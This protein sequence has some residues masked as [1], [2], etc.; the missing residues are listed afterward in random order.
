MRAA[1]VR[2]VGVSRSVSLEPMVAS[3]G[4]AGR[5]KRWLTGGW[6]SPRR[7]VRIAAAASALVLLSAG[8]VGLRSLARATPP[9]P[10]AQADVRSQA[11][12][13]T[14]VLTLITGDQV[15]VNSS[16]VT[17]FIPALGRPAHG[18]ITMVV[19]GHTHVVPNDMLGVVPRVL[20][21]SLFDVEQ[22]GAQHERLA[23]AGKGD[24]VRV[25]S[26]GGASSAVAQQL[27]AGAAS[28]A[29]LSSV[30]ATAV[31]VSRQQGQKIG[32]SVAAL[33]HPGKP[34]GVAAALRGA[35]PNKIWL[36]RVVR[37]DPV[38]PGVGE[39]D[40]GGAFAA[41]G[42]D[43]NLQQIKAPQAWQAKLTGKGFTVAVLDSGVDTAHPDLV[44]VVS[45]SK[46]FSGADT[47]DRVG[48]GTHVAGLIAGTGVL[49]PQQR[50]GVAYQAK[51]L[52]GKVLDDTGAGF[53][54]SIIDGMQWAVEKKAS[55]INMSLG[56]AVLYQNDPISVALDRL[57]AT[58]N[59]LFVVAAG[60][61]GAGTVGS[62]GMAQRALTVG[63]VDAKGDIAPFSSYGV[64]Y[65]TGV[66]P[67]LTAPGVKIVSD[68]STAVTP[69][70]CMG[71]TMAMSGT[72]MA[73]P[74]VAG[75]AV[76]V[77]QAHPT[78]TPAQV[79]AALVASAVTNSSES[80][81]SQGGG[82]VDIPAAVG[83]SVVPV[84]ATADAG[85]VKLGQQ[86][87]P[88]TG[89]LSW[90]NLGAKPV[91]LALSLDNDPRTPRAMASVS[92]ASITVPA[93]GQAKA[94]L[95]VNPASVSGAGFYGGEVVATPT[96]P[97]AGVD[98]PDGIAY[99]VQVQ[100]PTH[101]VTMKFIDDSGK[102]TAYAQAMIA[103]MNNSL[104]GY[105]MSPEAYVNDQGEVR[106]TDVPD[107]T[108]F[109]SG[110]TG[111][112]SN[113]Q[114]AS[115]YNWQVKPAVRV[116]GDTT[117]VFKGSDTTTMRVGVAGQPTQSG[118]TAMA[119]RATDGAGTPLGMS[120][121][122]DGEFEK[123]ATAPMAAP[124]VGKV[125]TMLSAN[126]HSQPIRFTQPGLERVNA[127][128]MVN[129][130]PKAGTKT[131]PLVNVGKGTA[132][133]F[134]QAK[135]AG[136]IAVVQRSPLNGSAVLNNAILNH[137]AM[138][139]MVNDKDVPW[140]VDL[141]AFSLSDASTA[142]Y[143]VTSSEGAALLKQSKATLVRDPMSSPVYNLLW[144]TD[145]SLPATT[146]M[147]DAARV[148]NMSRT[149]HSIGLVPGST[150]FSDIAKVTG[151]V[152]P[153]FHNFTPLT[154]MRPHG[155]SQWVEYND[156]GQW[157]NLTSAY[158]KEEAQ[159][160]T[161]SLNRNTAGQSTT[162]RWFSGPWQQPTYYND[163]VP[164]TDNRPYRV[165]TRSGNAFYLNLPVFADA[166]GH[167]TLS[168]F[169][170]NYAMTG[171]GDV[172]TVYT[173][174]K[175]GKQ[176]GRAKDPFSV[177][178]VPDSAGTYQLRYQSA[179]PGTG[180]SADTTWTFPSA[181]TP[182]DQQASLGLLNVGVSLPV[183]LSNTLTGT[184][185][186]LT[187]SNPYGKAE[188]VSK[189][190]VQVS[191]DAGKTWQPVQVTM[192]GQQSA[193]L[194]LPRLKATSSV[195]LKVEA[196][197]TGGLAVKQQLTNKVQVQ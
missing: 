83:Q 143:T 3:T 17:G 148:K 4:L 19:R 171:F 50:R 146:L 159:F 88:I 147:A 78:W 44:N 98:R 90:R 109:V 125:H 1:T 150:G 80:V 187:V 185:G 47:T 104:G 120:V 74:Q 24:A 73:T 18:A 60:N 15:V 153:Q 71:P 20:D 89:S 63:A 116:T 8:I 124:S 141:D 39:G 139:I 170:E 183:N 52:N 155:L 177:I 65:G 30:D 137:A 43:T 151:P 117:L 112:P 115:R 162:Q 57:A 84:S 128:E 31:T 107:G 138:V 130:S 13:P 67:E 87:S 173:L 122:A 62:P 178:P 48:H 132:Q 101:T 25:I 26:Q 135:A 100:A 123:L 59:S 77:R 40:A 133:E 102:P 154:T 163:Y 36:D 165:A 42:W 164:A 145:G 82:L 99:Q 46:S 184:Q 6:I 166:G 157:V 161:L 131:L 144:K 51:I 12:G 21:W 160:I 58:S 180:F 70:R 7:W 85:V 172:T 34:G 194:R 91:T 142:M 76:L 186:S 14:R 32:A 127:V 66:K 45:Q 174:S 197:T 119:V 136:A 72:S 114:E 189:L 79:K 158:T 103:D 41:A 121:L 192:T 149:Q 9:A 106:F 113:T 94:T 126:L 81:H 53:E 140:W 167:P 69:Q 111:S 108:Y 28:T 182:A 195:S 27:R 175:D 181:P 11:A 188:Q 96:G 97:G 38:T 37:V 93:G 129:Y 169:A 5:A 134:A 64:Q 49:A 61:D 86:N 105:T 95:S 193:S 196:T 54:S 191:G 68:C 56:G 55:V 10:D 29:F 92:P 23:A 22:L 75:S 16:G 110:L 152:D 118:M 176:L 156:P 179:V 2:G 35:T 33:A 190:S 168:G